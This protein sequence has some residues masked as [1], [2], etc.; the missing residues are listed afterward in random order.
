M[1]NYYLNLRKGVR[2]SG[3]QVP[4]Q[5]EIAIKH[6]SA[7]STVNSSIINNYVTGF[8]EIIPSCAITKIQL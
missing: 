4:S 2:I 5:L 1:S 7:F 6:Q 8:A 3:E